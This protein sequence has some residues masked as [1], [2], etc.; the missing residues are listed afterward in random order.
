MDQEQFRSIS[1]AISALLLAF[2]A[3]W[4]VRGAVAGKVSR[5][6]GFGIRLRA[7]LASDLAWTAGH[8]A[9]L[10]I[11]RVLPAIG[12][13]GLAVTTALLLLAGETVLPRVA[14]WVSLLA[15]LALIL[16]AIR[17]ASRAARASA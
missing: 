10:P 13:A 6:H 17:R 12:F 2:Y 7:T 16:E 11:A 3:R 15:Q 4:I 5:T 1:I 9:A 14:A 8:Y